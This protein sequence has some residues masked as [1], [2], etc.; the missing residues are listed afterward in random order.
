VAAKTTLQ[1]AAQAARV[2]GLAVP[3]DWARIAS[4]IVV[5]EDPTLGIQPEFSGY[6]GGLVKQADVTLL[7]YP[8]GYTMPSHVA[9]SD[10]NY[11]ASRTDPNGPSMSDA[12]NSIDTSA[13]GAPGCASFV[14]T[15][16]SE[17]P[18]IHD[19]F[20][21]F[22]ETRTGGVLTFMTGIGGFLQEFIY[23]YS[24]IRWNASAL[25]L[26]PSLTGQLDGIVL[27]GMSWHGRR[28]TVSIGQH[29]T[30]ITLDSGATMPVSTSSGVRTVGSGHTLTLPTRRPD[31]EPTTDALRCGSAAAT[32]SKPGASS[33]AAVDGSPATNWQALAIPATLTASLSHGHRTVSTVTLEWGQQWPAPTGADQPPPPGPVTILRASSYDVSVSVNG[34]NWR[35]VARVIGRTTGTV[36]AL[37]FPPIAVRYV[38][39]RITASTDAQPPMLDEMT[40]G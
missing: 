11:Y 2:L 13:L 8:W 30:S 27:H 32:S 22:S 26:S 25:E 35:T 12:V 4:G 17:Q 38:S 16:R 10:I 37:H 14:Y 1:D 6:D 5:P 34:H 19:V 3:T 7:E 29:T 39:V 40:A 31:L 21:Q 28:F 36:D 24:G 18:F 33:L 9:E 20:D 23:G 15:Q